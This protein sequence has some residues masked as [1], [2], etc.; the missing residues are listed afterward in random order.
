MSPCRAFGTKLTV[1]QLA[2]GSQR[3]SRARA[4]HRPGDGTDGRGCLIH[5]SYWPPQGA[6][7]SGRQPGPLRVGSDRSA[8]KVLAWLPN[9]SPEISIGAAVAT[10]AAGDRARITATRTSQGT[11]SLHG[12]SL[13]GFFAAVFRWDTRTG[14]GAP[15]AL[16]PSSLPQPSPNTDS[17]V[18]SS[19]LSSPA[20]FR[21]CSG[22]VPADIIRRAP[23]VIS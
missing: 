19:R 22:G 13:A 20:S 21:S 9:E 5:P 1:G 11:I 16:S 15:P 3:L 8:G 17:R 12:A 2:M 18:P 23:P 14:D 10:A 4:D 7:K 6:G